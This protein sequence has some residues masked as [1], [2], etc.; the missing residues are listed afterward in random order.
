[1]TLVGSFAKEKREEEEGGGGEGG[2]D[3]EEHVDYVREGAVIDGYAMH[4]SK[5]KRPKIS[6]LTL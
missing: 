5:Y 3:A 4:A 1:M 6:M 2:R